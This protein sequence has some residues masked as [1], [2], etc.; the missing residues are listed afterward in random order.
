M[1]VRRTADFLFKFKDT[2]S[3]NNP[4]R[5]RLSYIIKKDTY[6]DPRVSSY[7]NAG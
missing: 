6:K 3:R 1:M 4:G 2:P 7:T 5:I